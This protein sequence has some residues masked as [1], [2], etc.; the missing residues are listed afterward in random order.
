MNAQRGQGPQLSL[1]PSPLGLPPFPCRAGVPWPDGAGTGRNRPRSRASCCRGGCQRQ[2][3]RLWSAR[4]ASTL[5]AAS[6]T[7]FLCGTHRAP[8]RPPCSLRRRLPLWRGSSSWL[9]G[10]RLPCRR[11]EPALALQ[12]PKRR[13]PCPG[14]CPLPPSTRCGRVEGCAADAKT[15]AGGPFV[16]PFRLR[17]AS[18]ARLRPGRSL[19][20]RAGGLSPSWPGLW[21]LGPRPPCFSR[22]CFMPAHF[23]FRIRLAFF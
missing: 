18:P 3:G 12:R 13:R 4:R 9:L 17:G 7:R 21:P 19:R 6:A 8:K 20:C 22:P 10:A 23:W 16:W 5:R 14:G 2:G 11:A 1:A 15:T